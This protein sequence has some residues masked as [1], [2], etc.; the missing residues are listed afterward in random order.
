MAAASVIAFTGSKAYMGGDLDS[1]EWTEVR[2]RRRKEIRQAD[3]SHDRL[4]QRRRYRS[5]SLFNPRNLSVNDVDRQFWVTTNAND[6]DQNS[7]STAACGEN[8][9]QRSVSPYNIR[10]G[11]PY[12][13][14]HGFVKLL[15]RRPGDTVQKRSLTEHHRQDVQRGDAHL[16]DERRGRV[17]GDH[18]WQEP[19]NKRQRQFDVTCNSR[20]KEE[21][22]HEQGDVIKLGTA[23][24]RYGEPYGFVKFSNVKD[25]TKMTKALN[26]VWFGH[27]RV[28]AKV[29]EFE[30]NDTRATGRL[31]KEKLG[32]LK[33]PDEVVKKDGHQNPTR[34]AM[35]TSVRVGDIVV[36]LGARKE[37]VVRN[38]GQKK[39]DGQSSKELVKLAEAAQEKASN[40]LLRSYQTK[41][42]D[43][44]WAHNGLV[45]TVINGE[46]IPV[47]QNR[48]TD[49]GFNDVVVIPMGADKVYVRSS[50]GADVMSIVSSAKEFFK[51]VFSNW[52][53]WDKEVLPY[54][55]GRGFLR[56]DNCSV[57]KDRLDFARVLIATPNLD[58]INRVERVLVN[59]VEVEIKIVEE[60]GYAMGEDTCLFEEENVTEAS[61]SD[62]EEGHVEPEVCR[63]VDM[64]VDKIAVG[65]EEAA[66]NDF[67]G[68][69]D[70]EFPDKQEFKMSSEGESEGEPERPVDILSPVSDRVEAQSLFRLG[71]QG[72]AG[73][74]DSQND[75]LSQQSVSQV[76]PT[77][78][79]TFGDSRR[80]SGNQMHANRANSCPPVANRSVVS[81]PWS[82]EWL[83]DHGEAGV[84]FSAQK[85]VKEG[86]RHGM[87]NKKMD[88]LEPKRRKAG[89]PLRHLVHSLKQVARLPREDR[90]EIISWNI[91]GLCGLEKRKEGGLL[92]LW[93]SSE[94]EVWSTESRE[95]VLWCHRR[96][97]KS[98]EEFS[99]ANVYAPCDDG[100]K[101]G[102]WESI[103]TRIQ[104]LGRRRVCVCGDFNVVKQPDECRSSRGGSRSLDHIPFNRFIV[105]N[106]LIDLPLSGRK[107]TWFKGDGLSMSRLDRFLFSEEWCLAWPNCTQ[108]ARLR[109]LSDHCSLVFVKDKW[110]SLQVDGW[111][112]YVLKEK[113]R[114]IKAALEEWHMTY[115]QNLPS[116]IDSLKN[117][118]STLDQKGEEEVLSEAEIAE[119]HGVSSDLHSLSRMN[120][121][122]SWQ[123]SRARWLKEGDV[124]SKYFHSVLAGR[125]R[126]NVISVIQA[127]GVSIEGVAPIRLNQVECTSLTKP[128][129]EEEVKAAVWDCDSYKSPDPDGVNF[130]FIK[131]FWA[132][133]RGDV[134]RFIFEFH[135]NGKLTKGINSTF[136]ALIP[137][138]DSPQRLNDFRPISLVGNLYKILAKV[139]ANRLRLVIGSVM[140]ESQTAFVKDRQILDGIL[141]ANE[142]VDE[143]RKFKKDLMLFKVD[144]EK[145][146]DSVDWG[147]LDDVMGRMSFPDLWRKWIK[148]CVSTATASVLVNDSPTKEF[149]LERGLRQGDPLSPFIYLLAAEGLNVLME[150][151]V[152]RNLFTGYTVGERDPVSVSHL[153]FADDTLLLGAKSWANVRA[154]RAVLV[155]FETMSGLKVNFYKSMLVGVNI[156]DSWLG[157]AAS[158][159]CC[160]VGNIPFVYL[161][162]PIGG[163]WCWRMLVDR[164]G[165]WFRVL[166]A[167]YGVERGRLREGGRR[168]SVWWR[169]LE[170][171]R[172]GGELGGSWFGELVSKKVGDGSDTFFWTDPW[173][174]GIPLCE[175]FARLFDLAGNK[176]RT[177]AEMF[178]LGWGTD[179]VAWE[180]RRQLWAWE[181]EMSRECQSLLSN[182]SLQAQ[183]SDRWHGSLT[184]MQYLWIPLDTSVL[185]DWH[186]IAYLACMC[187]GYVDGKKSQIISRLYKQFPLDVR[188]DQTS[189]LQMVEDD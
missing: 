66:I 157:E 114:M 88:Q 173:V 98:G 25:V 124:N 150:T 62:C 50:E 85:R 142:V 143:A 128:F 111:G 77:T 3:R 34:H 10:S 20:R 132:E 189:L 181:E 165:L 103:S 6:Q 104:S 60:W 182:L 178:S 32:L 179:G 68:K 84:I 176:L 126:G 170:C 69:S 39:G 116:R 158:A 82:L 162:L 18:H 56:A 24:K 47:V 78:R 185:V 144:F 148:E 59:G 28:R 163:K 130:G 151:A 172:E 42:D 81:G 54:H 91:R 49:A 89:G 171:I 156:P 58:I 160:K 99:V 46:A 147:Y 53:R 159:L 22:Y 136:I 21:D 96:F 101:Q 123:Q 131:D 7:R 90:V 134:M 139:L 186:H 161:G 45:A 17:H 35:L 153:Q 41:S 110:K 29:A 38:E 168:G 15:H 72:E 5:R 37:H 9:R 44:Q 43:V 169:E 177:V 61:Q 92:T 76:C 118:L 164:E 117:R 175:R 71:P 120:A 183:S 105:E 167:R 137:K 30:R 109:G 8:L 125:R 79:K 121:S 2:R 129:S 33:G 13:G 64:L 113:F 152:A 55:R 74:R 127:D 154:L 145:A 48:I 40:I 75:S 166:A 67:Q 23:F 83:H 138:I 27:F 73:D 155:L 80:V 146:C 36:K 65:L 184:L 106:N 107:F 187:V 95:H 115:T 1:G 119:L 57:D 100:A 14:R 112:G 141:I 102:L 63:N 70:E 94:V 133:L 31:N 140:Y 12:S 51:L 16:F 87:R 122:I 149:P 108:T 86:G 180:W 93:D 52:V 19:H 188:Q 26:A 174:E 135:R 97:T 4:Q 11:S